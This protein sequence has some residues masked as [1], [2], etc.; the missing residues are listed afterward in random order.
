[1]AAMRASASSRSRP[2]R[3]SPRT[4]TL[5]VPTSSHIS[6]GCLTM[7]LNQAGFSAAP[8][9]EA[10]MSQALSPSAKPPR[11]AVRSW[12]DLAPLVLS[13]TT[14]NPIIVLIR[15]LPPVR[16]YDW[17]PLFIIGSK[18][19]CSHLPPGILVPY[20]P[21]GVA[22]IGNLSRLALGGGQG[23]ERELEHLTHAAREVERHLLAHALRHVVDVLLI[24][25]RQDDLRKSPPVGGPHLLLD[26]A[27]RQ[28][29]TLERDLSG[30]RNRAPHRPSGQQAHDRGRHCHAGRGAVLGHSALGNVDVER[31]V[32][33]ALLD[34]Q[35]I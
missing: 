9:M 8:P 7:L 22:W 5:R 6:S 27:D 28:H 30:H 16:R 26:A 18:S 10:T 32:G 3:L 11:V 12:P 4:F 1:M 34:I 14:G 13:R 24:P 19:F 35:L 2:V 33:R 15:F 25:L 20:V 17:M 29:Q 31:L 21:L 23:L